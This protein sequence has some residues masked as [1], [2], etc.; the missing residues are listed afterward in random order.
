L[1]DALPVPRMTFL[2]RSPV[3]NQNGFVDAFSGARRLPLTPCIVF[4]QMSILRR[5]PLMLLLVAW[6][7]NHAIEQVI[8]AFKH[9]AH[10]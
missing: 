8:K 7:S 9:T 6:F 4:P 1:V 10:G 5:A 3:I 2:T